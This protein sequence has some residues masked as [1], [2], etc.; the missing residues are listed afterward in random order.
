[1]NDK[2]DSAQAPHIARRQ[3]LKF[4]RGLAKRW[5]KFF[6]I[7]KQSKTSETEPIEARGVKHGSFGFRQWC[8]RINQ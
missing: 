2:Q 7:V 5:G 4:A 8:G 3:R 1:M 6:S